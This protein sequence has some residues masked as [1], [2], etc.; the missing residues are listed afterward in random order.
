MPKVTNHTPDSISA[1]S[2][3]YSHGIMVD[4]ATRWLHVSG[5][6]GLAPDGSLAGDTSAQM[7]TCWWR[8]FEIL[9]NAGMNKENIVKVTAFL[10]NPDE[11]GLYREVRDRLMDGHETASTLLIVAGLAHPDWTVEI[12]VVAAD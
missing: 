11:V 10:T 8:I 2:S 12:E 5:Q 1:P 7:E 4:G 9:G 6:V 3:A